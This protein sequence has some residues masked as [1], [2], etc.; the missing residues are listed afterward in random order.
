MSNSRQ[1][2][3]LRYHGGKW[4]LA[5][6]IIENLPPHRIYVEPFGGAASVL[7]RKP[8]SYGEVYNDLDGEIVNVFSMV[9]DCGEDLAE[10]LRRTPFARDEYR[11]SFERCEDPI[12]QA[13][14]TIIRSFMGFG[15]NA[16]CREVKSGFRSC[17]NRSGTTPAGDWRNYPEVL[18]YT[19]ERLRGVV[20]ENRDAQDVMLAH[21]TEKTVHYC[22][23]PYVHETRSSAA[24]GHH[25]YSYEMNDADHED[26][27]RFLRTLSGM[28]VV[29]GY[30]CDLYDRLYDGWHLV[31]KNALAD[32]ARPRVE[33]LWISPNSVEGTLWRKK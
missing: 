7:L 21:D 15:S 27:G 1:R 12:E 25:G 31:E 30:R 10:K 3:I 29:S 23:P 5:A 28:V 32:G 4:L 11:L 19:I 24:H 2:P 22:D 14:R 9:R 17:S 13:R 8:R 18:Q 26:L 16:L 6:W 20:I 33:C